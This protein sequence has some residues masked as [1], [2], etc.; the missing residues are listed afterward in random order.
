VTK[1][2]PFYTVF[3]PETVHLD[4]LK[5]LKQNALASQRIHI[6]INSPN[7]QFRGLRNDSR[8]LRAEV[9]DYLGQNTR[10]S[11]GKALFN[12]GSAH[13]ADREI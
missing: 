3:V 12:Y 2:G 13:R 11:F 9:W 4:T 7:K 6:H 1:N 8:G 10:T 5:R